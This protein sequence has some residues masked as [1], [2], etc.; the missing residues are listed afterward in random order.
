MKW[1]W[2]ALVAVGG[3]V[4]YQQTQS[5]TNP[6]VAAEHAQITQMAKQAEAKAV[7]AAAIASRDTVPDYEKQQE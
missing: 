1:F 3:W 7:Q 2:I 4:A 6:P 5:P